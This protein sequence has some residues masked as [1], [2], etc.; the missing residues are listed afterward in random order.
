MMEMDLEKQKKFAEIAE[1][2]SD[3]RSH[4]KLDYVYG[5]IVYSPYL[6]SPLVSLHTLFSL[7]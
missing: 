4:P 2:I 3:I 1:K 6:I 5:E 7:I